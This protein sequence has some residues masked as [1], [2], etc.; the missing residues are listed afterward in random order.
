M[1]K[2]LKERKRTH[3]RSYRHTGISMKKSPAT[4]NVDREQR[5]ITRV[6]GYMRVS[7]SDQV[8]SG[9]SLESQRQKL[10][11]ECARRGWE[12]LEIIVDA[13]VSGKGINRKGLQTV[14]S[15]LAE[16]D[17][18]VLL[19]A[20]LDRLSRSVRDVCEIG[21]TARM[22]RWSLVL[23]DCSID[24]TT[25]Y[26]NA[27][28]TMMATFAQLER[29]LISLRTREALAVKKAQGIKLGRPVAISP[30]IRDMVWQ[31]R[32]SGMSIRGIVTKLNAD[33]VEPTPGSKFH[34][35]T[36]QRLLSEEIELK[37]AA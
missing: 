23:M 20:K 6:I 15:R 36:I 3:I 25:P 29:E 22:Q 34:I 7:T 18:E 32:R 19:C 28:L 21:D 30:E 14:L 4:R 11:H 9:L 12:I 27:Q 37:K 16:G 10:E 33:G 13:G 35:R 31:L 5:D 1:S 8:E 26:G 2:A 24:T 17:A